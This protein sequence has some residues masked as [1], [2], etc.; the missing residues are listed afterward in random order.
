M[1]WLLACFDDSN[2]LAPFILNHQ[3]VTNDWQDREPG[4]LEAFRSGEEWA[5][6]RLFRKWFGPLSFYACKYLK[7]EQLSE[8]IV[9]DCFLELWS[10]RKKLSH[11][12]A[13]VSYLHRTV[14]HRV[15]THFRKQKGMQWVSEDN[16]PEEP[17]PDQVAELEM[18]ARIAL[19]MD[20]LP[21]RMRQV[22]TLHYLEGKSLEEIGQELHI[23]PHTVRQHRYRAILLVRKTIITGG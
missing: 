13:V 16:L 22:L 7:D 10:R 6:D 12:E 23:D 4:F 19:V 15:L 8:D 5:F 3:L 21:E 14:Y 2:S 20:N 9:Q 11:I 1:R 17:E 18:L